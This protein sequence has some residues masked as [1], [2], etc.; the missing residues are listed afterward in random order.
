MIYGLVFDVFFWGFFGES[1]K[2]GV[3]V[4]KLLVF[5]FLLRSFLRGGGGMGKGGIIV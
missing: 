5:V 4:F 1:E 2:F 3:G